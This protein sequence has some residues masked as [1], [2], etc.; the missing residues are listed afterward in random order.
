MSTA[1]IERSIIFLD[2]NDT[3]FNQQ[4]I[5]NDSGVLAWATTLSAAGHVLLCEFKQ[6]QDYTS[7]L[8]VQHYVMYLT[9]YNTSS[10][11]ATVLSGIAALQ[12]R[13]PQYVITTELRNVTIGV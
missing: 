11:D 7:G 2:P 8:P 3:G 9:G 4:A 13:F 6:Y 10:V 1:L 12:S 5:L